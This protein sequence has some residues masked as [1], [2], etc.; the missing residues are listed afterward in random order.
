MKVSQENVNL[1]LCDRNIFSPPFS[2]RFEDIHIRKKLRWRL[3]VTLFSG[4]AR[5]H[6][7]F[8]ISGQ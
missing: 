6:L 2:Y 1:F 3:S 4:V 5:H 7:T 8:K